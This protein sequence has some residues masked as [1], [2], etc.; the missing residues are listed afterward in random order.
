[1]IVTHGR[2]LLAVGYAWVSY[3]HKIFQNMLPKITTK[4]VLIE[5]CQFKICSI[6]QQEELRTYIKPPCIVD[7]L[8]QIQ[9]KGPSIFFL[10]A[11]NW[12]VF[13]GQM[14][15]TPAREVQFNIR[16]INQQ[17]IKRFGFI[18]YYSVFM[19][20]LSMRQSIF[21]FLRVHIILMLSSFLIS[22]M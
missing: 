8:K 9:V 5:Y 16:E 11:F 14:S 4:V 21:F 22:F 15:G 10:L 18:I 1:M 3:L 6:L 17:I 2:N 19:L 13:P 20:V 12:V 7:L